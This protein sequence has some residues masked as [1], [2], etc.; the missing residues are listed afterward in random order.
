M[1]RILHALRIY[2]LLTNM[3]IVSAHMPGAGP[4]CINV[5]LLILCRA[6]AIWAEASGL[7]DRKA[8]S[9]GNCYV[10]AWAI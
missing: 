3:S 9:S 8:H 4:K 6:I 7:G 2:A 10:L 1:W 5:A